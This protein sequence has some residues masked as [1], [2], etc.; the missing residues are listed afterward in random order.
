VQN[1]GIPLLTGRSLAT[2]GICAHGTLPNGF[3]PSGRRGSR[4]DAN[5]EELNDTKRVMAGVEEMPA[6]SRK[7]M[8]GYCEQLRIMGEQVRQVVRQ[9][10]ARIFGGLN[11]FARC[12][13]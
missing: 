3:Q 8:G 12:G 1:A 4:A 2:G 10:K 5:D 7:S 6:K 13:S 11:E 9:T